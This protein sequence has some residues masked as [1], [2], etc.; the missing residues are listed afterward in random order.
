MH[1]SQLSD[2]KSTFVDDLES[3]YPSFTP[4]VPDNVVYTRIE[5]SQASSVEDVCN[6]LKNLKTDIKIGEE[7]FPSGCVV[8]G[9]QQTYAIMVNLMIFYG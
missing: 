5:S 8:C 7:G 6:F 9:D 1:L 2:P 4:S 3:K